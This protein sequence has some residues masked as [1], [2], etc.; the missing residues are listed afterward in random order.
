MAAINVSNVIAGAV[1][2]VLPVAGAPGTGTDEVQTITIGG[3]ITGMTFKL[4]LEG[5][6]TAG[7]AWSATNGTLVANIDAA[8]EA[9]TNVGTGG[10]TV[11]AGSL[12]AG[13]G[14]ITAT[15]TGGARAKAPVGLMTAAITASVA[16]TPTVS[17]ARTTPG[18]AATFAGVGKGVVASDTTNGKLYQN[19]GTAAVPIWTVVGTQT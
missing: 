17:V 6:T 15:F 5:F 18:V 12:T 19:T 13:I 14:T 16:T 10:V 11:A 9:L 8:L 3:T 7:I 1:G 4:T 2:G